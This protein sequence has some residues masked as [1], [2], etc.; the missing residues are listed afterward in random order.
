MSIAELCAATPL[1][2]LDEDGPVF[3]EPWHARL[4]GMT[5][6]LHQMGYF[7]WREWAE[8]LSVEIAKSDRGDADAASSYYESW[9]VAL[10]GLL[11]R[12]GLTSAAGLL[13]TQDHTREH[14]PHPD[15]TAKLEPVAV[16]PATA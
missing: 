15:H 4:F 1:F 5:V 10:E 8:A 7:P 3:A 12:K 6:K 13:A 9:L 14:W 11:T 2:P 16:S